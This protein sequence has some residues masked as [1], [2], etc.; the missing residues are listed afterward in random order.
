[1]GQ[2][3]SSIKTE[4]NTKIKNILNVK[5]NDTVCSI[6]GSVFYNIYDSKL[7][8]VTDINEFRKNVC[9]WI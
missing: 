3:T 7:K 2:K 5:V 6:N 8:T 1:M 4:G 9:G